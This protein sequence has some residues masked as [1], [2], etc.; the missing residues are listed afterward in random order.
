MKKAAIL[1]I[2]STLGRTGP[3]QQ[4]LYLISHLDRSLF[5]PHVVTLSPEPTD[6]L[7]P[8]FI[9]IGIKLH[10]LE[11]SRIAG[12]FLA[13]FRLKRFLRILKPDII[14]SQGLRADWL[15]SQLNNTIR[16]ATQR[17][18]PFS[19]YPSLMG[20]IP[21]WLA[22]HLHYRALRRLKVVTCSESISQVNQ[23]FSL[24]DTIIRNGVDTTDFSPLAQ[25]EVTKHQRSE[26]NLPVDGQLFIYTGPAINRKNIPYLICTFGE[27]A[28]RNDYLVILGTGPLL[29]HLRKIAGDKPNIIF[30]GGVDNVPQYLQ[31]A[32][33]LVSA[34]LDEGLPNSVL[35]ALA[36]GVPVLLSDI[37][38]HREILALSPD[39]GGLFDVNDPDSLC[40]LICM[41][42]RSSDMR[43]N[44]RALAANHFNCESMSARYQT[45]YHQQL[46]AQ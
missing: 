17:N 3:T 42:A 43:K 12:L 5:D 38:P 21:G 45:L 29:E 19:D 34:S 2:V 37:P 27:K 18:N 41:L 7:K 10:S 36:T 30:R 28:D 1:Y 32:D 24:T 15:S 23:R 22:A 13:L 35:E 6:S 8:K 40:N 33:W 4:L 14:H 46:K 26:L 20:Q 9:E 39:S 25:T 44:A 11:L 31:V 16:I